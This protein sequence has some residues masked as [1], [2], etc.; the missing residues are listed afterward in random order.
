MATNTVPLLCLEI[1]DPFFD[2]PDDKNTEKY[3]T[4]QIK[5][6]YSAPELPKPRLSTI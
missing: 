6:A 4:E 5:P 3:R 2:D 1:N